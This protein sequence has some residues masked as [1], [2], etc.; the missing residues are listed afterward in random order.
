MIENSEILNIAIAIVFTLLSSMIGFW[1]LHDNKLRAFQNRC[2]NLLKELKE[3]LEIKNQE[4]AQKEQTIYNLKL[5]SVKLNE[6]LESL[7]FQMEFIQ[8]SKDD[9]KSEFEN[10]ANRVFEQNNQRFTAQSMH[11]INSI[12]NPFKEQI[13]DFYTTIQQAYEKDSLQRYSLT[14]EIKKLKELNQQLSN[15]ATNLANALKGE[16]KTQ[17]VWGEFILQ[18]VLEDSGLK[19]GREYV[20][21]KSLSK[22]EESKIYRPDVIVHLPNNKD[23][24]IDSKVSLKAYE[25]YYNEEDKIEKEKFLKD[26][27]NSI[28]LHIKTLSLKNYE[29]L[30][31]IE[32]LDFVLMFIPIEGAFLQAINSDRDLFQRAY[33]QNIIIVSPSTLLATLRTIENIWRNQYLN[34]NAKLIAKK[35]ASLHDKFVS[36]ID[37]LQQAKDHIDKASK[38][39]DEAYKKLSSGKGNLINRVNELKKLEGIYT[40]RELQK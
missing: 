3:Q 31:K 15:D 29:K 26:H 40:K 34:Q 17:G 19:E 12:I 28:N 24:I 22:E 38:S 32:S 5:D 7:N 1:L 39:Y 30:L 37:D 2:E 27:I 21:Q 25:A 18:K 13:K 36:F 8:K 16:N 14:Y 11:N 33:E 35:A 6:K 20:T 10:L 23:I 9:L 4:L